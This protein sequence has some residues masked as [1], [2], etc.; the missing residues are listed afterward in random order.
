M[1][2]PA[3]TGHVPV[4]AER[5]IDLLA[6]A[7]A[8]GGQEGVFGVDTVHRGLD[9]S[10]A[11]VDQD[12]LVVH[13][14]VFEVQDAQAA[15]WRRAEHGVVSWKLGWILRRDPGTEAGW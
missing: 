7:L 10:S 5:T 15:R 9:A 4:M 12:Q 6:P 13:F 11:Q 14:R 8:E 2:Q 1:V 3:A